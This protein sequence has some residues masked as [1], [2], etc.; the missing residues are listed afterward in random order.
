MDEFM[1]LSEEAWSQSP[2]HAKR[3]RVGHVMY[4][5]FPSN[6]NGKTTHQTCLR[7]EEED[8]MAA[9]GPK[10]VY[11]YKDE[12]AIESDFRFSETFPRTT[13]QL[14]SGRFRWFRYQQGVLQVVVG[15]S[16][17]DPDHTRNA[18]PE[19]VLRTWRRRFDS[20][21][22]LLCAVEASWTVPDT[23]EPLGKTIL[24]LYDT[25]LGPSDPLPPEPANFGREDE[26]TVISAPGRLPQ[27]TA[28]AVANE[29]KGTDSAFI[30]TGHK[31]GTLR[32]WKP[33]QTECVWAA[34]AYS[35]P[36]RLVQRTDGYPSLGIR[37][38]AIREDPKRG[39]GMYLR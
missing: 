29:G 28:M 18:D 24:P 35:V 15:R 26:T 25:D 20:V 31:D 2:E 5:I 37:G 6:E 21:H 8:P 30:I 14:A 10:N 11:L 9:Y 7:Q 12:I 19:Q 17:R 16:V 27:V 39:H 1:V 38:I 34:C 36:D 4:Y 3:Y 22:E 33:N 32:K 13:E 23:T